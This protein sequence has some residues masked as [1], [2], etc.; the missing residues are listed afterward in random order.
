[1]D[2][3]LHAGDVCVKEVLSE[4][5]SV[6]PVHAVRGNRDWLALRHMPMSLSLAF[7][8]IIVGVAHGHG[9]LRNYLG[10]KAIQVV[11]GYHLDLYRDYLLSTLPDAQVII[12]GHSHNP[13]CE[14]IDGRLFFNPGSACCQD[15]YGGPP[16]IGLLHIQDARVA[17][18]RISLAQAD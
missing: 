9:S 15:D 16:G 18:E 1:M 8:G 11:R 5:A 14:Y 17:A 10:K 13:I 2:A 12:F 4:L 6:A 7:G 3:I